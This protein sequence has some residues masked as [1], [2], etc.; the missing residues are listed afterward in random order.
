[1]YVWLLVI[2]KYVTNNPLDNHK[3]DP[4]TGTSANLAQLKPSSDSNTTKYDLSVSDNSE[5]YT[6]TGTRTTG[7]GQY[8]LTFDPVRKVLVLDRIDS[9][10]DMNLT[11][12]PW[13]NDTAQLQTQYDQLE[14]PAKTSTKESKV[15][16]KKAPKAKA[17]P[18]PKAKSAS[19]AKPEKTKK[20]KPQPPKREPT[21]E[22][23]EEEEESDDGLTVEYP[24]GQGSQQQQY[25]YR[26]PIF[27]RAPSEEEI[28]DEDEDMDDDGIYEHNQDV[29]HL[30]LP[31]PLNN[32]S[33]MTDEE[34]DMEADFEADL[35]AEL[36]KEM[37]QQSLQGDESDESEEE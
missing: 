35:E 7:D 16:P 31:S 27:Q 9:T 19:R 8:V 28:S 14:P 13:T 33:V 26:P 1:M 2:G 15:P 21:P 20:S 18:A 34:A 3:P 23:E 6:Y 17:P 29:D 12:A 25:E 22:P 11:S 37:N 5:D 24:D 32:P 4:S 10:F 36:E 30:K